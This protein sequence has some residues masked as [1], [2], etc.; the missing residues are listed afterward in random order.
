M[1]KR[2]LAIPAY[3]A[4]SVVSVTAQQSSNEPN[5]KPQN[6]EAVCPMH[7]THSRMNERGKQGMGFSQT[8]TTHHFFLR[9]DGG[10]VQVESNIATDVTNRD[11]I[12]MHRTH[13][14]QAFASG[15]FDIPMFVHD[16][17]PP[18]CRR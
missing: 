2:I 5:P 15:D 13:I 9:T 3:L 8:A 17:V 7:D 14:A 18:E 12:R 11:N 4:I 1:R 6:S 16:T 10:V